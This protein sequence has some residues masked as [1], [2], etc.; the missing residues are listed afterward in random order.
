MLSFFDPQ[1]ALLL[2][3]S[4][5]GALMVNR[6]ICYE[7]PLSEVAARAQRGEGFDQISAATGCCQGCGM[8]EPYVRVTIATGRT[9]LPVMNR[10]EAQRLID[11]A[12][13]WKS[14]KTPITNAPPAR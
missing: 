7:V 3:Q 11:E 4:P 10:V 14:R 8:C 9:D 13:A 1:N 5:K 12:V 6:C 2:T